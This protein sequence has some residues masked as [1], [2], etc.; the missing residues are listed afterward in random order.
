MLSIFHHAYSI[1]YSLKVDLKWHRLLKYG[2][3][4]I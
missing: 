3:Y 4:Y 1:N 2:F